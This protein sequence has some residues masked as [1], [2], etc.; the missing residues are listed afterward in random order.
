MTVVEENGEGKTADW[1]GGG[2][3]AAEDAKAKVGD[4][5]PGEETIQLSVRRGLSFDSVKYPVCL[6]TSDFRGMIIG[7]KKK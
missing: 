1:E 7:G 4:A 6:K 2:W 3:P 5:P